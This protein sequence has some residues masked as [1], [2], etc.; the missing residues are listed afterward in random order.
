[1]KVVE[2]IGYILD[3]FGN[4]IGSGMF[5]MKVPSLNDIASGKK[6]KVICRFDSDKTFR[7]TIDVDSVDIR[8][9][10][11]FI[12]K[13]R[14]NWRKMH[15]LPMQHYKRYPHEKKSRKNNET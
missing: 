1:M 4:V 2:N 6:D 12:L 8:N 15:G 7:T 5:N 13:G 11:R 9:M 14:N 10:K 3:G